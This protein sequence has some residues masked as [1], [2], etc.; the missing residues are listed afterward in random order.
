MENVSPLD[1]YENAVR[2]FGQTQEEYELL[3]EALHGEADEEYLAAQVAEGQ[4]EFV[5]VHDSLG[6][7]GDLFESFLFRVDHDA[8]AVHIRHVQLGDNKH[9][10]TIS[11]RAEKWV[12]KYLG[13]KISEWETMPQ[14]I[15]Q[16]LMVATWL[17]REEVFRDAA[18]Y[19]WGLPEF[20]GPRVIAEDEAFEG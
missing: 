1:S 8:N 14:V 18:A 15:G 3:Q 13:E 12:V 11:H 16:I 2:T 9:P 10:L 6:Y 5:S 17:D 20:A 19:G 4:A 7:L